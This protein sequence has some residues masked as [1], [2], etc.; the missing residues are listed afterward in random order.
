M[1]RKKIKRMS[2]EQLSKFLTTKF[3][4]HMERDLY[5]PP[6]SPLNN[7]PYPPRRIE[8]LPLKHR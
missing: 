1:P 8:K 4:E 7:P 3:E 6:L 5:E 2:E